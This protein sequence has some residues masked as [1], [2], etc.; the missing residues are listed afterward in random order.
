MPEKKHLLV[1]YSYLPFG[2]GPRNCIG[3][4]FAYQEIRLCLAKIVRQFKFQPQPPKKGWF[5]RQVHPSPVP[6]TLILANVPVK[7]SKRVA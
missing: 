2:Q 3:M 7:V 6:D 1:P 4:R 5:G